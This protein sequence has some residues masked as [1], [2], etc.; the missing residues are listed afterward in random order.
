[1]AAANSSGSAA[2]RRPLDGRGA[3]GGAITVAVT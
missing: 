1:M 2:S 3:A